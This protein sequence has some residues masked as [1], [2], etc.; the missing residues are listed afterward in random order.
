MSMS[1]NFAKLA[2][3]NEPVLAANAVELYKPDIEFDKTY[4]PGMEEIMVS[5]SIDPGN[6]RLLLDC[7]VN[8]DCVHSWRNFGPDGTLDGLL[9]WENTLRPTRLF[10]FYVE[11]HGEMTMIAAAAIAEKI[12]RDF[13]YRGFCV[14]GRCYIMPEFR[15]HGFYRHI[16]RY[17]L[18]YCKARFGDA[19]KAVHIGSVNG[20]VSRV[21]SNH[22]LDGWSKFIHLGEEELRVAGHIRTVGAY[23]LLVPEYIRKIQCALEGAHEPPC[24]AELRDVLSRIESGDISNLGMLIKEPFKKACAHGWF[25]E[26]GS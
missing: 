16:L 7:L 11:R 5:Q 23:M 22:Q 21:I 20:R 12:T 6:L 1:G 9:Q 25:N 14:L 26:H 8:E 18:E 15:G 3:E 17:R 13:P 4:L 10:F 19:L 24:V 2:L